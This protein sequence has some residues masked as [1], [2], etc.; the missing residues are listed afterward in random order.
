MLPFDTVKTKLQADD[1]INPVYK[2]SIHVAKEILRK[3]G[4]LGFYRGF[5]SVSA[6]AFP[7]NA[8]LFFV[9]EIFQLRICTPNN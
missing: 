2:N 6:R 5:W 9:Y 1:H 8:S 4:P 3:D 7:V